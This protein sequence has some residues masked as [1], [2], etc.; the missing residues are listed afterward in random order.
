MRKD[1][2]FDAHWGNGWPEL[3]QIEPLFL[4]PV[5]RA[6]YFAKGRDGG[7]FSVEGLY[8]TEGLPIRGGL[9][10]ATLFLHMSPQYGVTLQYTKWDGRIQKQSSYNSKGNLGRLNEFVWSFHGTPLSVGLFVP[11]ED[12]WRA[13]KEFIQAEGELPKSIVWVSGNDLPPET[14]PDLGNPDAIKKL[15]LAYPPSYFW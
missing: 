6:Q 12:G 15:K 9:V 8:G 5:A 3:S 10:S 13:V 7:N 4:D 2:A 1:A 14:F 11:F